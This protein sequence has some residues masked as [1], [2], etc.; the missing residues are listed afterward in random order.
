MSESFERWRQSSPFYGGNVQYLETLYERF[1]EDPDSVPP[2]WRE[3][4]RQLQRQLPDHPDIPHRPVRQRFAALVREAKAVATTGGETACA[5]QIAVNRLIVQYRL[6]G[7]LVADTNPLPLRP[8]PYL[9]ELDPGFYGLTEADLDREFD[10]SLI[11]GADRLTLREILAKLKRI[12]C[13]KVGSETMHILS[14]DVRHWVQRQLET[15][16]CQPR[17]TPEEKRW[18]LKLL[19][20]AEGIEKYLHR[21]YVGQKRFSLEGGESLIPLLDE[22]IQSAGEKGIEEMVMGMA[23]RGRL[24]VLVNILGKQPES[25]FQEF[26]GKAKPSGGTTGDV[27]YH[28]GFSSDIPTPGG[29]LHLALAFNPSHLEIIDPVAEGSTR[30]RQDRIGKTGPDRVL[31]LLIHGDAAFA[32]QGVVMET[33]QMAQTRAF[34]TGGT[35][36]VVV[37]NQIG[38][39]IS[40]PFDARS[41][42]YPTDVAKMIEAPVFHVNGDDPEAVI[43]VIRLALEFRMTFNRDVVIDLVCY[44]RHGHNEADEPAVTQPVMYRHIRRHPSA[45]FLYARR[46]IEEGVIDPATPERF[47]REYTQALEQGGPLLRQ[48]LPKTTF[49]NRVAWHPYV[50]KRWDAPYDSRFPLEKLRELA[51]EWLK[52]P[53]G[54]ELHPRVAKIWEDR[55]KMTEGELPVDWGYAENMAYAT[56]LA[57]GKAVRL[58]GQDSGRGTFFHRHGIV[59]HYKTGE[60]FIPLKKIAYRFD[61]RFYLYDSLLSEEG[62][63]GFEY[64]YS[65]ADPETLVIWE[66]QFGDF[67]NVAQVVID[68]FISSGEAKWG[69]LS[70]LTLFLPHGYEGQGPE[71]SSARLERFLQLCAEDNMQACVP[72]TPAQIFHL[73]RRQMLRPYRKPLITFTP[74]SLLRH[75]L[76]V[77]TLE[78]LAEGRFQLVIDETDPID[79]DRVRRVI[80]C[81]GKLYYELLEARRQAQID[82]IAILRLEQLYPFPVQALQQALEGYPKLRELV[83]C[84]EEPKNQ[85]AWYQIRHRFLETLPSGVELRY[86][87]RPPAAAPA[88]GTFAMHV[89]RQHAII[90]AALHPQIDEL[91]RAAG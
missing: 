18:I 24:N 86:V 71:H 72:T 44:R 53:E 65:T 77:S 39:T 75:R 20:A 49:R 34:H 55:R 48:P 35:V 76:A 21:R 45:A 17:L 19:I 89:E 73:L 37:N 38:F 52:L 50:G 63:L 47:E 64:G 15:R 90:E 68:Q 23:H 11:H 2:H 27:K 12:Y 58:T 28:L 7:H 51:Y 25:L 6:L 57:D 36:H 70:G 69:R 31:P 84:Q 46:L 16:E 42:T 66:A 22:L 62:V 60:P 43:Y 5:K 8:R 74:K 80:L 40:N 85:G 29:P 30:A 88:E 67:A 54:F 79:R 3:R 10:A 9:P 91:K 41:T 56:L 59:Y 33:L 13:G 81:C 32:A 1:L 26:E 82:D 14:R 87:G 78:E 4:F 61:T 83:W